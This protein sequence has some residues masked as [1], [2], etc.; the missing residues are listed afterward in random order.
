MR[1]YTTEV[2][3]RR[4]RKPALLT[5]MENLRFIVRFVE[6]HRLAQLPLREVLG[7]VRPRR[8]RP[9]DCNITLHFL[10][11]HQARRLVLRLRRPVLPVDVVVP[12]I[13][14]LVVVEFAKFCGV[15]P[16]KTRL[17]LAH[18]AHL[19]AIAVKVERLD[20]A[21]DVL[22]RRG[23]GVWF[24][25]DQEAIVLLLRRVGSG[26]GIMRRP[27]IH[28]RLV[29]VLMRCSALPRFWPLR[30]MLLEIF[31]CEAPSLIC[32]ELSH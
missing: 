10:V 32:V 9:Y 17:Q 13:R 5:F 18:F 26:G 11:A 28:L 30:M 15:L 20:L 23:T 29:I 21:C 3:A 25:A 4:S 7:C 16:S 6:L 31:T 24:G 14:A 12:A 8:P 2:H 19:V 22:K 1:R 27:G